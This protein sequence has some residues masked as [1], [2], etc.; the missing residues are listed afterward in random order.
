MAGQVK[1]S[2]TMPTME[3]RYFLIVYLAFL[4]ILKGR[5]NPRMEGRM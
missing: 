2:P 5:R 3:I 4:E 1:N